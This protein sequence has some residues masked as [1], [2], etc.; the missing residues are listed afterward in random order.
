MTIYACLFYKII[1][2]P[3][4]IILTIQIFTNNKF[5]FCI[6]TSINEMYSFWMR[7]C[8]ELLFF[9]SLN[10]FTK[11][12]LLNNVFCLLGFDTRPPPQL[13]QLGNP[14]AA[15][16]RPAFLYRRYLTLIALPASPPVLHFGA[17]FMK[18]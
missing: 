13:R 12:E 18:S 15:L 9:F 14:W 16:S 4:Q 5:S 6:I 17:Y 11:I 10:N 8:F 7:K 2:A 3:R 1:D